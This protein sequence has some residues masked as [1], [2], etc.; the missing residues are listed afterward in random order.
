MQGGRVCAA[1]L[2]AWGEGRF[3]L[4]CL[5]SLWFQEQRQ[6]AWSNAAVKVTVTVSRS[7]FPPYLYGGPFCPQCTYVHPVGPEEGTRLGDGSGC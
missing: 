3:L 5:V 1:H 4:H 7:T 6:K 2:P